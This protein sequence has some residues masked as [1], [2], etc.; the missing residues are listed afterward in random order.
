MSH[1]SPTPATHEPELQTQGAEALLFKTHFLSPSRPAALKI[2]PTKPYR[3]PLLDRRLTRARVLQEARCL[4]KISRQLAASSSSSSAPASSVRVTGGDAKAAR[5]KRKLAKAQRRHGDASGAD[6]GAGAGPAGNESKNNDDKAAQVEADKDEE[7]QSSTVVAAP[8]PTPASTST[9]HSEPIL[10]VPALYAVEFEPG[11]SSCE[12]FGGAVSR[13]AHANLHHASWMLMEWIPGPAVRTVVD[14]WE[15]WVQCQPPSEDEAVAQEHEREIRALL[16]RVGRAVGGLH[17]TGIVHG[18]LT[19]SNL[20]LRSAPVPL[21]SDGSA[22]PV[23]QGSIAIIDFGLASQSTHEE[24]RAVD[25]YV[26]ERAFGSSH[27]R[28]E[29][30]F[31]EEVIQHGYTG[32]YKGANLTLKRL[33]DVRMRGRKKS[34]IG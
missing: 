31:D 25:L 27:P 11:A 33:E 23:L 10:T 19:T 2:R 26:L 9:P 20:M 18:D 24:D 6:S 32:S 15:K 16:A 30:M 28:T 21:S 14:A 12:Y 5:E 4:A 13:Q 1:S 8:T 29:K 17:S 34:M 7:K 3:H 22:K